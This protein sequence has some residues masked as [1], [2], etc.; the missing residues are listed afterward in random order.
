MRR[1]DRLFDLLRILRGGKLVT[2]ARLAA[3]LEVSE[4]TIYRDM[5]ALI[6]SGVPIDGEAGVGYV[7][8]P[9]FDLPPLMFTDAEAEALALGARMVR[10]LGGPELAGAADSAL[11]RIEAVLPDV[12]RR[13]L[14]E[15]RVFVP[16]FLAKGMPA[17]ELDLLR[18]AIRERRLADFAYSRADGGASRR[19]VRPLGLYFWG[20]AWTLAAWCELRDDFRHFRLD[21]MSGLALLEDRFVEEPGRGLADFLAA[22]GCDA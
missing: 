4:R 9:G 15:A 14:A 16:E 13:A 19:R 22:V 20:K 3:R 11:A 7:L 2:A 17:A 21:R 12:R 6:L 18:R 5:R 1:A 8:R 10:A